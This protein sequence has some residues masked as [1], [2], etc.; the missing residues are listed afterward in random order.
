MLRISKAKPWTLYDG[1][2]ENVL[3]NSLTSGSWGLPVGKYVLTMLDEDHAIEIKDG[4]TV[5]Y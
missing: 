1:V 5:K 4:K 3:I 2:K